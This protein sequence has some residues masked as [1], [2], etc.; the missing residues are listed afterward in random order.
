MRWYKRSY[1]QVIGVLI[2]YCTVVQVST[3]HDDVNIYCTVVNQEG[4]SE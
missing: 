3:T 2:S 4:G 1:S